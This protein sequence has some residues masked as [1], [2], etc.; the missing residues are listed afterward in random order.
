MTLLAG[1]GI[2]QADCLMFGRAVFGLKYPL[3]LQFDQN[4]NEPLIQANLQAL[5]RVTR[6]P[7]GY[8]LR[9]CIETVDPEIL[10]DAYKLLFGLL[11]RGKG[12]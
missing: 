1:R 10:R 7:S 6:T 9:E 3:L 4:Q 8:I 2:T 12:L 11:Q 5:Y